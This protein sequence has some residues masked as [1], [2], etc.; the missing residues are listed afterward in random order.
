MAQIVTLIT[1]K[2]LSFSN[3][4]NGNCMLSFDNSTA[5]YKNLKKLHPGGDSNPKPSVLEAD[6]VTTMPR[7]QCLAESLAMTTKA[8]I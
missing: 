2:R 6:A 8:L 5:M 7:F 3:P 1:L 4:H